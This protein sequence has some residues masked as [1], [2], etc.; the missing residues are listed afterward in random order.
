MEIKRP[1]QFNKKIHLVLF[2]LF[3]YIA[4]ALLGLSTFIIDEDKHILQI[5]LVCIE[6]IAAIIFFAWYYKKYVKDCTS[7]LPSQEKKIFK[8]Q[9]NT[10][11][12]SQSQLSRRQI[13][14][15]F[16]CM[17]FVGLIAYLLKPYVGQQQ[18]VGI[19]I[20]IAVVLY[21]AFLPRTLRSS[22]SEA[23]IKIN[24]LQPETNL[25]MDDFS[26][27][28]DRYGPVDSKTIISG[29]YKKRTILFSAKVVN[30]ALT[31]TCSIQSKKK[32]CDEIVSFTEINPKW[33][34]VEG[35]DIDECLMNRFSIHKKQLAKFPVEVK[36]IIVEYP[37]TLG[38]TISPHEVVYSAQLSS[39]VV[40]PYYS[41]EGLVLFFDFLH[42][43]LSLLEQ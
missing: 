27:Q 29:I 5:V 11:I 26:V 7:F 9:Y 39:G 32:L 4:V 15:Y 34:A 22:L 31:I 19:G 16:L 38:L 23:I 18:A 2:V 35:D 12:I 1:F 3:S 6:L 41:D 42:E 36:K 28:A 21:L 30:R 43:V 33:Q 20:A 17:A 10:V 14:M 8:S 24:A 37:R 25:H 13:V 40:L